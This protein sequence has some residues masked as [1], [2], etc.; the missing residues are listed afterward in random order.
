M[1]GRIIAHDPGSVNYGYA[2][3][4]F[5]AEENTSSIEQLSFSVLHVGKMKSLMSTLKKSGLAEK[6]MRALIEEM[7]SL[8]DKWKPSVQIAERFMSRR[9]GGVTIE[10]VNMELGALRVLSVQRGIPLKM[11]PASQWK[12]ELARRGVE[13]KDAEGKRGMYWESK[14]HGIS[15]HELDAVWIG[16]Y[17]MYSLLGA[18]AFEG[19]TLALKSAVSKKL[20]RLKGGRK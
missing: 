11:I 8:I 19:N 1:R 10:L 13:L 2:I 20:K 15:P 7:S 14:E 3:L 18:R 17:G 16:I 9:M 4:E 12:N 5:A 6:E